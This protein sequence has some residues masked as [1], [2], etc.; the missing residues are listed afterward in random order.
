MDSVSGSVKSFLAS[1]SGTLYIVVAGVDAID[2]GGVRH[3]YCCLFD[4]LL[5]LW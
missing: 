1:D 2:C 3:V 5:H 4:H